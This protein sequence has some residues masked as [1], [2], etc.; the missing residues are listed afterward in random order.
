MRYGY[1]RDLFVYPTFLA[2]K[3]GMKHKYQYLQE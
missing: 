1:E 3:M 2:S